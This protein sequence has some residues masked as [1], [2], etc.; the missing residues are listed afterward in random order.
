[1]RTVATFAAFTVSVVLAGCETYGGT[2]SSR[3]S[4]MSV[5]YGTVQDVRRGEVQAN[6]ARGA[7]LGGLL[8]L[9]AAA[10]TGGSRNQQ[11]AGAA[12]G[13]L[14]GGL[15]QNQRAANNQAEEYTV[16][17]NNGRT[18]RIATVHHDIQVGDCVSVEQG[19]HANI[20]RVSPV[21]CNSMASTDHPAFGAMHSANMRE[22]EECER[23]KQ[24]VLDATTEQEVTVAHQ[25]MRALCEH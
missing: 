10:G 25:K 6:T 8:G 14:V 19:K 11:I 13:A 3:N 20:R 24:E 22:A 15:I 18:V 23:A 9:A 2:G 12:V 21:M 7:A 5:D 1:M 17:L 16:R 4:L